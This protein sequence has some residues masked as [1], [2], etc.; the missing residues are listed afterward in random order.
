MAYRGDR[1][2]GA[3]VWPK[4][5]GVL[6]EIGFP[7]GFQ[8]HAPGFLPNTVFDGRDAEWSPLP[9]GF[10]SRDSASREWFNLL[11]FELS[12]ECFAMFLKALIDRGDGDAVYAWRATACVATDVLPG[13]SPPV[14]VGEQTV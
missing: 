2:H 14:P 4:T 8:D 12:P 9:V 11:G 1:I 3:T 6:T 10:W 7:Y 5:R 13:D